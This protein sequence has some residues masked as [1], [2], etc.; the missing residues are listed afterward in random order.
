MLGI[1]GYTSVTL[2]SLDVSIKKSNENYNRED[3]QTTLEISRFKFRDDVAC[4]PRHKHPTKWIYLTTGVFHQDVSSELLLASCFQRFPPTPD[5]VTMRERKMNPKVIEG[6]HDTQPDKIPTAGQ[7]HQD[8]FITTLS[9]WC[10]K[11]R[12]FNFTMLI[13]IPI[14]AFL[15]VPWV[16]LHRKTLVLSIIYYVT[17]AISVTAGESSS[18]ESSAV[19]V[20]VYV[21]FRPII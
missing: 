11:V 20:W 9:S 14:I 2:W 1:M 5:T 13:T 10:N 6:L 3:K 4:M 21:A 12:W 15:Q 19:D 17:T 8:D 7:S 16:P 18:S